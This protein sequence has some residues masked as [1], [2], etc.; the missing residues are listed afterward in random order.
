MM[1]VFDTA[2]IIILSTCNI[3]HSLS[4][5]V[6]CSFQGKLFS[7]SK[8]LCIVFVTY[9]HFFPTTLKNCVLFVTSLRSSWENFSGDTRFALL[10]KAINLSRLGSCSVWIVREKYSLSQAL[11]FFTQTSVSIG[12]YC[13]HLNRI[14]VLLLCSHFKQLW[15]QSNCGT[16]MYWSCVFTSWQYYLQVWG[17]QLNNTGRGS[18]G[19]LITCS[20]GIDSYH[21]LA[22]CVLLDNIEILDM[23]RNDGLNFVNILFLV[24]GSEWCGEQSRPFS[25]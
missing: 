16:H 9:Y 19:C 7:I 2:A 13:Y 10:T 12:L 3:F 6:G 22:K 24:R 18:K 23:Y 15:M 20:M 1:R 8:L 11:T 5:Q 25:I 21:V 17:H 14:H 4:L